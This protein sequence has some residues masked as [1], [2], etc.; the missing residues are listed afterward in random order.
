MYELFDQY[1]E[2]QKGLEALRSAIERNPVSTKQITAAL[3]DVRTKLVPKFGKVFC[4]AEEA[5]AARVLKEVAEESAAL[6]ALAKALTE[7]FLKE[8]G[9]C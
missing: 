3:E 6:D 4:A 8:Q 7:D 2:R 9:K 5:A 1:M